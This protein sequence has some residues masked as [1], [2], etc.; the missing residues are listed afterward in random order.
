M[1]K[2]FI[3]LLFT[4]LLLAGCLDDTSDPGIEEI[5]EAT[6][7]AE[8]TYAETGDPVSEEVFVFSVETENT[9]TPILL[10]EEPTDVNG[11]I[12]TGVASETQEVIT[13]II[14]TYEDENL[15]VLSVE[16]DVNLE[17]RFEEPLDSVELEFEI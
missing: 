16:E 8:F 12:E 5:A 13:R 10:G 15:D 4:G 14:F 6:V 9:A 7:I 2:L 11:V 17:L 1:K 3:P